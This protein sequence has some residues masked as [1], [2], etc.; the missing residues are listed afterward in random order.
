MGIEWHAPC[1]N[2]LG[3]TKYWVIE[4]EADYVFGTPLD[5][6][7]DTAHNK[8]LGAADGGKVFRMRVAA[9]NALGIGD[10]SDVI[11][12]FAMDAPDTPGIRFIKQDGEGIEFAFETPSS[13]AGASAVGFKLYRD[14]GDE[15]SPINLLY[16]GSSR[17]D[18]VFY[19]DSSAIVRGKTYFYQLE[20]VNS[21]HASTQ[22]ANITIAF[23][24]P[25]S[26]ILATP[27]LVSSS[28]GGGV[29][30]DTTASITIR[31]EAAESSDFALTVYR[32]YVD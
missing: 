11:E 24:R 3:I 6:G 13:L 29:S 16:D 2:G 20:A 25:P 21:A 28:R 17:P 31:W 26:A 14:Q 12:L 7:A 5:K 1:T 32:V 30:G 9:E 27:R 4:D 19:K 22:R 18:V 8:T 23:G 15:G 10:Y